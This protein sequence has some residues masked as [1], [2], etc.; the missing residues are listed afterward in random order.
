MIEV[1]LEDNYGTGSVFV[2]KHLLR[3]RS[4]NL[5]S[6]VDNA[7]DGG[8][9]QLF[10]QPMIRVS[11]YK[12]S[13][14]WLYGQP[15]WNPDDPSPVGCDTVLQDLAAIHD[16]DLNLNEH[17]STWDIECMLACLEAIK[18]VLS[19]TTEALYD[20]ISCIESVL[21]KHDDLPGRTI[22]MKHLV[23]GAC[24]NDGG[25][26]KWLDEYSYEGGRDAEFFQQVCLGFVGKACGQSDPHT[27]V[28]SKTML[29]PKKVKRKRP[30]HDKSN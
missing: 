13:A 23:H 4:T 21:R 20:P 18:Q 16:L 12:R 8:S 1:Q 25:T 26:K 3:E 27:Q 7:E 29:P 22:I 14:R 10:I 9:D 28:T 30:L 2:H 11:A 24:A 15:M 5:K 19:Q 6:V 17:S